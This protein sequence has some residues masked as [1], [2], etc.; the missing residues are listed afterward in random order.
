ME[1]FGYYLHSPI[2]AALSSIGL[3][4][5]LVFA[6]R[7]WRLPRLTLAR[8]VTVFIGLAFLALTG[9]LVVGGV[10]EA[11]ANPRQ[12]FAI[13]V[14]RSLS[15]YPASNAAYERVYR[16]VR[17]ELQPGDELAVIAFDESA[18][19]LLS[20]TGKGDAP[21]S[22]PIVRRMDGATNN[23][24]G[25][26]LAL[27]EATA[28]RGKTLRTLLISDGG[29][30]QEIGA[31]PQGTTLVPVQ[32][33]EVKDV[34]LR[35]LRI[36]TRE[37]S[38]ESGNK[39]TQI[40]AEIEIWSNFEVEATLSIQ[41]NDEVVQESQLTLQ[42]GVTSLPLNLTLPYQPPFTLEL[43]VEAKGDEVLSN[44]LL[45]Q[46]VP[47][48][49][50]QRRICIVDDDPDQGYS[51]LLVQASNSSALSFQI[52]KSSELSAAPAWLDQ[53][54]AI[55]IAHANATSIPS[56]TQ[57]AIAGFVEAGGGF[58]MIGSPQTFG[59]GGYMGSPLEEVLPVT[60]EPH[61]DDAGNRVFVIGLDV[62]G[63]M[64]ATV[65]SDGR[66]KIDHAN[67]AAVMAL[68]V[69]TEEDRFGAFASGSNDSW[70]VPVDYLEDTNKVS[71]ALLSNSAGAAGI[72]IDQAMNTGLLALAR[73]PHAKRFFLIL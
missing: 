23:R 37:D 54:D 59:A 28:P 17:S 65:G 39:E 68:R 36:R 58:A 22:F 70:I 38:D 56:E 10:S 34:S 57:R 2:L 21:E 5:L 49:R 50:Q 6:L 43:S 41:A 15:A 61:Q 26:A 53:W 16:Q 12:A 72:Y 27:A 24:L 8:R 46:L 31:M 64:G 13:V 1:L 35:D 63:S 11:L 47:R 71:Q 55:V 9:G 14:D 45:E 51:K 3:A 48:Q 67:E 7:R 29:G 52:L 42:K 30:A 20:W 33:K 44:N 60:C 19:M 32:F 25:A 69:I 40:A 66:Q 4:G 62:S 18:Q 73:D